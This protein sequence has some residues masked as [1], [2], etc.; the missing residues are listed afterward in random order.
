M[1]SGTKKAPAQLELFEGVAK[2]STDTSWIHSL[3]LLGYKDPLWTRR[4]EVRLLNGQTVTFTLRNLRALVRWTSPEKP[5]A[6]TAE[7]QPKR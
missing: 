6:T 7:S 2:C 5:T 4:F 1:S 3:G